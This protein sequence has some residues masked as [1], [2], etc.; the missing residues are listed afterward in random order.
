MEYQCRANL[1]FVTS[2][3]GG[4]AMVMGMMRMFGM[5]GMFGVWEKTYS[6]VRHI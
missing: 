3:C 4:M 1:G 2:M 5:L 6:Y